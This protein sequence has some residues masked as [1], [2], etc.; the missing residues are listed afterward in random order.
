MCGPKFCSMRITEQ[1]RYARDH[2]VDEAAARAEGMKEKSV[3][4]GV[5]P[6]AES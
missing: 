5:G 1:V 3:C 6:N 4:P 2:G